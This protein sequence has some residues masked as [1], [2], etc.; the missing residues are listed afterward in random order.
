[1]L[2]EA[3]HGTTALGWD[4]FHLAEE[5]LDQP[6]MVVIGDKQGAFSA[7]KDGRDI[8]SRAA[9]TDKELVELEDVSHYDLYDRPNGA[10]EAVKR[11]I[12]FFAAKL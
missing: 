8:H 3:A 11:I 12:P 1:M 5:L 10:G 7:Y 6:L 2:F 4:A 9:S